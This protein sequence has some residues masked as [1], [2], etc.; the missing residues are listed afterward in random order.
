MRLKI[1][2]LLSIVLISLKLLFWFIFAEPNDNGIWK[3]R[4]IF[5]LFT[6]KILHP[7]FI[8]YEAFLKAVFC[9][10]LGYQIIAATFYKYLAFDYYN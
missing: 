5:S 1:N 10:F 8:Q 6:A 4:H 3:L 9:P 2:K 7:T